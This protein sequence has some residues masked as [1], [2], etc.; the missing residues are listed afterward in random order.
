MRGYPSWRTKRSLT[1]GAVFD[2]TL[3]TPRTIFHLGADDPDGPIQVE[4]W[5]QLGL[6]TEHLPVHD[7]IE[8]GYESFWA[9]KNYSKAK[10]VGTHRERWDL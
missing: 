4:F 1:K 8:C 2:P 3:T 7:S 6:E 5:R 9:H 10:E